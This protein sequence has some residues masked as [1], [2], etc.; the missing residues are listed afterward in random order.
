MVEQW[1]NENVWILVLKAMS[2]RLECMFYRNL[3]DLY[4][5]GED[6]LRQRAVQKQLNAMLELYSVL[7]RIMLHDLVGFC[8][9]SM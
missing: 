5:S 2:Y 8:P 7:D 1:S 9:L 6:N 4:R 3:R